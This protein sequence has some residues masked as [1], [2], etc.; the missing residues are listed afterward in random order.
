V[1]IASSRLV[2]QGKANK[3]IA[4]EL[5]IALSTVKSHVGSV[6]GKLGLLSRTQLALYADQ[7]GLVS[8]EQRGASFSV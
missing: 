5:G 1:L 3:Q 4:G 2:A 7:T 8:L 6:L